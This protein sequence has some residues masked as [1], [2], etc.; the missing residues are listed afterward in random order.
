MYA[1]DWLDKQ[2]KIRPNKLALVDVAT[3]REV[4]YAQFNERASRFA[5]F[6][7]NDWKLDKGDRVAVLAQNSSDYLEM[8]Y[9]CAKAGI[10][11]VCLN[12]RLSVNELDYI[13][14]DAQPAG[15]I[16][17]AEFIKEGQELARLCQLDKLMQVGADNIDKTH[18]NYEE[19]L[20]NA[21][22]QLLVMNKTELTDTWHLLY[23]SGTTGKP[24]GVIQTFAMVLFNAVNTQ[25]ANQLNQDDVFLNVL[26]FFHTGG[27]NLYTNPVI[28]VGGTN[29]IM[30][31]FDAKK[32]MV[33]LANNITCFFGVPAIYLFICQHAD[34]K[35][36][37]FDQVRHWGCGG[38]PI[39]NA[40]LEQFLAKDIVICFGYGM[41]ETGPLVFLT[42]EITAKNKIGT[43]GKPA[44][45]VECKIVNANGAPQIA[46]ECGTL[47]I[48]GPSIT[49]GYWRAEEASRQ[50]I[51]SDGWLDSG[52]IA[53]FD[54]DG[55]F[56]IVDRAKDMF[57]S[58]GEN[59]YPA[60]IENVIAEIDDIVDV[61]VIGI[62]DDRWVEVGKAILV[63]K[64]NST[65]NTAD[66]TAYCK[67][68]LAGYK[69]PKSCEFIDIMPRNAAGKIEKTQL[70]KLYGA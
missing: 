6:L 54:Q 31:A 35:E 23:T 45:H 17:S 39:A 47:L 30:N 61:A 66:I 50:A 69:V 21:S 36:M 3:N 2:A 41:T 49:P 32:A 62:N 60:E 65:I 7:I 4:T 10:V 68:R 52:D 8:L 29:Y 51:N 56:F 43:V 14:R 15:L 1:I 19:C 67:Q 9:G 22:G 18:V 11:M 64:N 34:F 13:M 24:K 46:N 25:L 70:R 33:L 63:K 44:L 37:N 58:G 12:W 48:R 27:L 20:A 42:D 55:D 28:H 5:E 40:L 53:Y 59:V 38:S 26:P 16:F 57:I